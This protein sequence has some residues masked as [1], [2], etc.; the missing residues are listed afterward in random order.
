MAEAMADTTETTV[1]AASSCEATSFTA[2]VDGV[3]DPVELSIVLD[4]WVD[5]VDE[6]ALEV[7]ESAILVNPVRVK[8]A[9]GW[10]LLTSL[11]FSDSLKVKGWC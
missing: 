1:L 11:L 4:S 5:W 3:A 7:L 9:E 6:D 8:E 2:C 10:E